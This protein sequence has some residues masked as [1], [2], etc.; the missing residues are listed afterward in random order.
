M[1]E[2]KLKL[3]KL[4]STWAR[5]TFYDDGVIRQSIT[6]EVKGELDPGQ[7]EDFVAELFRDHLGLEDWKGTWLAEHVAAQL[8]E[9]GFQVLQVGVKVKTKMGRL[10][11]H[12]VYFLEDKDGTGV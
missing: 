7:I 9:K 12:S 3:L 11:G 10:Q 1:N 8:F 6:V 4:N 5:Y 2:K